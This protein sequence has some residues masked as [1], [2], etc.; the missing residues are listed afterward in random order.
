MDTF[1]QIDRAAG[2]IISSLSGV[3]CSTWPGFGTFFPRYIVRFAEAKTRPATP[4]PSTPTRSPQL[5][6]SE[7]SS[8]RAVLSR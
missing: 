3:N 6:I 5:S 4:S 8:A 1:I 7:T 2:L